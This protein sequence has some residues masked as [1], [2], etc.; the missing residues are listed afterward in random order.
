MTYFLGHYLI[1]G[2]PCPNRR[3]ALVEADARQKGGVGAGMVAGA[4]RPGFG[5][6]LIDSSRKIWSCGF[7]L[8]SGSSVRLKSEVACSFSRGPPGVGDRPVGEID[9][10]GPQWRTC[11]G[12]RQFG[13]RRRLRS[14]N[15][16][17]A[18]RRQNRQRNA[19]AGAPEKLTSIQTCSLIIGRAIVPAEIGWHESFLNH[20]FES[21]VVRCWAA[22]VDAT[23]ARR[24]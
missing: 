13:G 24:F 6:L 7:A 3:R 22:M 20:S 8:A 14:Q 5:W 10:S 19:S 9:E 4:V 16:A 2:N 15:P 17:R 21:F 23:G 18:V 12:D 11:G 1:D